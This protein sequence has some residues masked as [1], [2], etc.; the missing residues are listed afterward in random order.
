[1]FYRLCLHIG[2][3]QRVINA[4]RSADTPYRAA[5]IVVGGTH[6]VH[7]DSPYTQQSRSDMRPL[8][9]KRTF[10]NNT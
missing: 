6:P 1:M 2:K 5:D 10:I 4:P 9:N 3:C 7:G 8:I